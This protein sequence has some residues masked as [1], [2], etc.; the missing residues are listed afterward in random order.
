MTD[1]FGWSEVFEDDSVW[2]RTRA[3]DEL[4][5]WQAELRRDRQI[6]ME[7]PTVHLIAWPKQKAA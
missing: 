3:E 4:C 2:E 6:R 7:D 1:D 5:E